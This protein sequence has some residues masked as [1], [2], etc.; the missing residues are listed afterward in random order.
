ML[1]LGWH[2]GKSM[3]LSS[4]GHCDT[5]WSSQFANNMDLP[6]PLSRL[7]PGENGKKNGFDGG[8]I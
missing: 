7:L 6:A 2:A 1:A 4:N 5:K 8:T 3:G